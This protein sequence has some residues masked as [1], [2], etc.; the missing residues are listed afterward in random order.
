VLDK[1]HEA[2]KSCGRYTE[3][4]ETDLQYLLTNKKELEQVVID[5]QGR[6]DTWYTKPEYTILLGFVLGVF[7][8]KGSK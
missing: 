3:Q 5:V 6:L 7:T 8:I 2:L 1:A 4:L